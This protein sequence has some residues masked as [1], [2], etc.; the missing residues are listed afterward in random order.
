MNRSRRRTVLAACLSLVV[1]AP[2]AAPSA[3]AAAP[4]TVSPPTITSGSFGPGAKPKKVGDEAEF[5]I[6]RGGR[7]RPDAYIWSLNGGPEHTE[8]HPGGLTPRVEFTITLT[9]AGKNTMVAWTVHG[10]ARSPR[11]EPFTFKVHRR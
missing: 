3:V 4:P 10:S 1:A 8:P 2:L 7:G 6:T 11:S 9:K 5:T